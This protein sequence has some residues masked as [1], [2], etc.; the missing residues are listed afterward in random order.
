[1]E[2]TDSF[3]LLLL[4]FFFCFV[5]GEFLRNKLSFFFSFLGRGGVVQEEEVLIGGIKFS[6]L[7]RCLV[8]NGENLKFDLVCAKVMLTL[9]L[10]FLC[11]LRGSGKVFGTQVRR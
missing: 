5:E 11:S 9:S 1:M 10:F 3:S 7:T 6:L 4:L 8:I 2:F